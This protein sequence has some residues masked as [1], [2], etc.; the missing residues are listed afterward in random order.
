M[1]S[2]IKKKNSG[3]EMIEDFSV[4]NYLTDF[5]FPKYNLAIEIDEFGHV[6]RH[7]VNKKKKKEKKKRIRRAS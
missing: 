4:L 5:C 1:G 3:E 2:K 6:D 7:S